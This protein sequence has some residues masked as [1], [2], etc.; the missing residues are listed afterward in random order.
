MNLED[1]NSTDQT[2]VNISTEAGAGIG[3]H[4]PYSTQDA[5]SRLL[6]REH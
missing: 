2:A 5:K 1:P 4:Q 6:Q 3:G